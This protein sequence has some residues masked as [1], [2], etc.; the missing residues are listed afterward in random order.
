MSDARELQEKGTRLFQKREY[1]A[2]AEAFTEA[3][4]IYETAGQRDMAAEMTVNIGLVHRALGEHDQAVALMQQALD[5][6]NEMG[7]Q[8]RAAQV[9]GNLGGV[10]AAQGDTEQA[11]LAYRQAADTFKALGEEKLYGQTLLALGDLQMRSGNIMAG[12]TTYEVGL[13]SVDN[14]SATQKVLKGLL[15]VKRRLTGI[16]AA[17][18]ETEAGEPDKPAED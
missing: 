6:F 10:F 11:M 14:L 7:D 18:P 17:P 12:A 8:S 5:V 16:G 2:A 9:L 4:A 13:D 15:G 1:E 3:R